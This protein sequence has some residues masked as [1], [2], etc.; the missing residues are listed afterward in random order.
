MIY[1]FVFYGIFIFLVSLLDIDRFGS[2]LFGEPGSDAVNLIVE[3]SDLNVLPA[4]D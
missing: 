4:F 1:L 2:Y 3:Q